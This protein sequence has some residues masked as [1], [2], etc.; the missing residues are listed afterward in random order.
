MFSMFFLDV[1]YSFHY[2]LMVLKCLLLSQQTFYF[3]THELVLSDEL[4]PFVV[5]FA[6]AFVLLDLMQIVELLP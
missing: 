5:G 3:V 1:E 2:L 4:F 6:M